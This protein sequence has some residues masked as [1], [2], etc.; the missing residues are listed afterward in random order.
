MSFLDSDD[1]WLNNK[2]KKLLPLF[3][4]QDLDIAYGAYVLDI[5]PGVE[6]THKLAEDE[7]GNNH[8]LL[9][10]TLVR[11][12]VFEKGY[13]L[14]EEFRLAH[15]LEWYKRIKADGLIIERINE[16]VLVYIIHGNNLVIVCAEAAEKERLKALYKKIKYMN[17][18]RISS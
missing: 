9:S 15:D 4:K 16:V 2:I 1:I 12:K 3:E 10:A 17:K 11:K 14:D 13:Y 6:F 18:K 7:I 8:L 5:K